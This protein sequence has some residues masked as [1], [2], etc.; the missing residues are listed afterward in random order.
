MT[1]D[2]IRD[3][4]S[5]APG[6]VYLD[7]ATYGLPPRPAVE[8][9][10]RALRR[11]QSG[12][13]N[14][15]EEWDREGE[16]CRALF[17]RLIGAQPE[18]IAL[19]PT[20]SVGVGVIAASV[21]PGSRILVPRDEFKSVVLPM[22]AAEQARQARVRQVPFAALAE[23][24]ERKLARIYRLASRPPRSQFTSIE[25]AVLRN[26]TRSQ[27]VPITMAGASAKLTPLFASVTPSM[28]R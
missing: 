21:P 15:I 19:I 26:V 9:L 12:E 11:W 2:E 14:W 25:R 22:L 5:P 16:A 8:A 6:L 3:L 13:A 10:E 23:A 18:N 17:A 28:A 27:G 4:F 1:T 7:A 20:V 24:I